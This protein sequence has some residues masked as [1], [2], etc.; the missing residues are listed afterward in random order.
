MREILVDRGKGLRGEMKLDDKLFCRY[1]LVLDRCKAWTNPLVATVG[2]KASHHLSSTPD[3]PI[4]S[5]ALHPASK[6]SKLSMN[7][8]QSMSYDVW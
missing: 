3:Q 6:A 8:Q 1:Q 4:E 2:I 5:R 7:V